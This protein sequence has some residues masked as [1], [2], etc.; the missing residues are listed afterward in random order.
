MRP[1]KHLY[2]PVDGVDVFYREAGSRE[3][4]SILLL[5]G[6]P[7]SSIQFRYL[8]AELSDSWHL[9]APDL[10][11]F[12]FTKVDSP[13]SFTFDNLA[14]TVR[15]FIEQIQLNVSAAYLHDYGGH[16]G[17]RLLTSKAINPDAL[18]IQNTEAYRGIGWHEMM[19]A[20][21]KRST[22]S[23]DEIRA[24]L[25]KVLLNKEGIR[26]EFL[27]DL[28]PDIAEYIDPA[29]IEL[30]WNKINDAGIQ[31]AMLDLHIDYTSNIQHYPKIQ[32]YFRAAATPTLL[33]WG[34]RDQYISVEAARAYERDLPKTELCILDGGHWVLESHIHESN[35]AV[36]DFLS[37]RLTRQN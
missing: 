34:K 21:D 4:P 13:Y 14:A 35:A 8:L 5:H 30:G 31:E 37:R 11:G 25:L 33:L 22:E 7:S 6:F 17:F 18:I 1:V 2:A 28:P 10:P 32:G 20:I 3:N 23:R 27:E 24:R 12:G 29:V 15:V 19:Q 26:K 36:R 9:I 16:V